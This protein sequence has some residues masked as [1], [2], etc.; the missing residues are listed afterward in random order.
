MVLAI[1]L[2]IALMN[3][4]KEK[5][6]DPEIMKEETKV[7]EPMKEELMMLNA[8]IVKN[9]D[10]WPEIVL[11]NKELKNVSHATNKDTYLEIV[12]KVEIKK[13]KYNAINVIKLDISQE[14]AQ[15]N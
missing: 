4:F 6:M 12:P 3:K 5:I 11:K 15:V 7:E 1:W 9:S 13:V 2:E 14:I 10:I 8:T